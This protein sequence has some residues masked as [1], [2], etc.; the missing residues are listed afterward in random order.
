L[1]S[2]L[3]KNLTATNVNKKFAPT[4]CGKKGLWG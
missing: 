3:R 1:L 4:S 2:H